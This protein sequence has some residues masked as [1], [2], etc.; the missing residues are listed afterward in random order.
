MAYDAKLKEEEIKNKV[1]ADWFPG[2][3]CTRILGNVDFCVQPKEE[4][5]TLWET[6]SLLWAEAKAGVRTELGPLFAQLILTIGREKTHERHSP[7]PFLGAFDCEKIAFLPYHA[8][9]D[10]FAAN[11]FDWT[12]T[13]SDTGTREFGLLLD[14]VRP[15]LAAEGVVF[16]FGADRREL[17]AFV[18]KNL[19]A[20]RDGAERLP[21]TRNNFVLASQL[22]SMFVFKTRAGE[23][24]GH[25]DSVTLPGGM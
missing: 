1:A 4:G 12:V 9:V 13:P 23:C 5:P 6:E 22:V 10:F 3:D 21:V 24:A 20:G 15:L 2:Y 19:V 25:V 8:V 17:A 18:K 14:R 7:P 16:R 11:D